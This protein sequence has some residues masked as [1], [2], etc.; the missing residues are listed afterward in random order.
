MEWGDDDP[1]NDDWLYDWRFWVVF[2]LVSLTC[3]LGIVSEYG[4]N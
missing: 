1:G 4:G 2:G 3:I